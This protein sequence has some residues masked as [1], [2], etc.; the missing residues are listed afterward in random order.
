MPNKITSVTNPRIKTIVHLR[1]SHKRKKKNC[2]LVEGYREV[3]CALEAK[4]VLREIYLCPELLDD[5]QKS[6]IDKIKSSLNTPVYETTRKVFSQI[7]YGERLEGILAVG[8]PPQHS[9]D[10]FKS[11]KDFL[12]IVVEGVEKPGNLG[13]IL[14]TC[15]GAGV[16][17]I[18]VCDNQT[19][20]YNPNVIRSSLGTIFSKKV[21]KS[22]PEDAFQFLK[23][24]NVKICATLPQ[25]QKIYTQ[26]NLVGSLAIVVG[27]EHAGLSDFWIRHADECVRIPMIGKADSL[28]VSASTAILIYETIRQRTN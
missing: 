26:A 14:R 7:S 25:A 28:N 18:I 20:I 19:D 13:A 17:G 3:C 10:E 22:S 1:D 16:D 24:N 11:K 9:F 5:S 4:V 27:S 8:E 15:D 2:I 12:F 6:R 21:I 23:S